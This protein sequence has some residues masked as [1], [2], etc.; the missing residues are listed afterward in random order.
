ML[1]LE[2]TPSE[3]GEN[4]KNGKLPPLESV[5]IHLKYIAN[6]ILLP[7]TCSP[8]APHSFDATPSKTVKVCH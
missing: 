5:P 4:N 1:C 2:L 8:K 7:S 6:T 3:K